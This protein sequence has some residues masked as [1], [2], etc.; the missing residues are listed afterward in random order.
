MAIKSNFFISLISLAHNQPTTHSFDTKKKVNS[1]S[2]WIK[3]SNFKFN[4]PELN[5]Y[6]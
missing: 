6:Y 2:Y 4:K 3:S 1:L 5:L